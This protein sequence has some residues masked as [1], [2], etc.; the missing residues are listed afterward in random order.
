MEIYTVVKYNKEYNGW[1]VVEQF[2]TFMDAK[3][4]VL[5][6]GVIY[7]RV[8]NKLYAKA[9]F[10]KHLMGQWSKIINTKDLNKIYITKKGEYFKIK[11]SNL[12]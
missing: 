12:F 5:F 6:D 3:S 1:Q 11:K 7:V 10:P 2:R 9:D 8:N 4:N